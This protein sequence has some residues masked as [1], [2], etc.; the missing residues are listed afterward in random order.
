M[1]LEIRPKNLRIQE[2]TSDTLIMCYKLDGTIHRYVDP[3]QVQPEMEALCAHIS[4]SKNHV[5]PVAA[6][7]HYHLVR[8]HPFDNGNGRVGRIL[9]NLILLGAGYSPAV[10]EGFVSF[11]ASAVRETQ[12]SFISDLE[13]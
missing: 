9:M 2:P 7:A 8:I 12:E 6:M 4:T 13:R 10:I 3:L 5:I 1:H 11:V